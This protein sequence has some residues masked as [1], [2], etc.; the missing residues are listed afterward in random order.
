MFAVDVAIA[1]GNVV[2]GGV[3]IVYGIVGIGIRGV[4]CYD[5]AGVDDVVVSIGVGCVGR[6]CIVAGIIV[7]SVDAVTTYV[8]VDVDVRCVG[9]DAT[10]HN[11]TTNDI[12]NAIYTTTT[13][14]DNT[15]IPI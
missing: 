3:V 6:G 5:V 1:G 11:G 9:D 15:N 2:V 10:N 4:G 12:S 7:C 8:V 13:Y 14:T